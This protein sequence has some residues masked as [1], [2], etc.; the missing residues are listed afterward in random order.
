MRRW[1]FLLLALAAGCGA[2]GLGLGATCGTSTDAG[3]QECNPGLLCCCTNC[4]VPL[5]HHYACEAP[6]DSGVCPLSG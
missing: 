4:D 5:N 1:I 2:S 6:V 3:T